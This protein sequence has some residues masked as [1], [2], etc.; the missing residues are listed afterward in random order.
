M[1]TGKTLLEL[2]WPEG[3]I[4]GLGLKAAAALAQ[5]ETDSAGLLARLEQVRTQPAE[6]MTDP[7]LGPVAQKWLDLI[8]LAQAPEV[9]KLRDQP[10]EVACWGQNLIDPA[11]LQQMQWAA[12]LPIA[13]AAAVM[14]DAHVGYGLP[15]GGVLA[16]ENAV[17][18]YGV[19]VDIACRMRL[20][21][22]S[23]SPYHLDQKRRK[24]EQALMEQTR[25]GMG[26][27]W[28]RAARPEHE[29]MDDPAWSTDR[30]LRNLKD[31]AWAQLGTSGSGNHFVE[32]GALELAQDEPALKLKAGN[33]LA[34][35]SHS[36][37][38]GLG[39]RIAQH[40]TEVARER[41]P[42]LERNVQN[43]AWLDLDSE[44]G[45]AYWLAMELAGRYAAANHAVIHERVLKAAGLAPVASVENH[46]NFAWRETL[47]DGTPVIVHRKGAT[48]AG[49]GVLGIIPGSMGDP[50]YL[51][52]GKGQP[53]SLN[54]ASHGA[55]R[56]MGRNE[57]IRRLDPQQWQQYLR[58]RG[59][60]LLG[61]SLDEAPQ[62]YKPIDEVM[63]AQSD[64]VEIVARFT[65]RL[66]RMADGGGPS[67]D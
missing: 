66:V 26:A 20:S 48:P 57:A 58:E 56:R 17:I 16:T 62:A 8:R 63:A 22:C 59:I 25:F 3:P 43:L 53:A 36:G 65:P 27:A 24:F 46:H 37:S 41:H 29:V 34:L 23:I 61:G 19:G 10:L 67:E 40:F 18:P 38:R 64:L 54:S 44:D 30:L 6:W 1:I 5:S 49:P 14:A 52:R 45:Q 35:L 15:I 12:R 42:S 4:I 21:I 9:D 13:K 60:K 33:Y 50:G 47:A 28:D 2:G 31:K 32:W 55:G 51:V 7:V 39:S 11:S